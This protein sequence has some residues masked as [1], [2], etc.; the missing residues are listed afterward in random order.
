MATG[1]FRPYE[2]TNDFPAPERAQGRGWLPLFG[3]GDTRHMIE[4]LGVPHMKT[5]VKLV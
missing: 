4:A 2:E 5:K 3:G 1:I